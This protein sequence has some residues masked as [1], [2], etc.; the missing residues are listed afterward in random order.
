MRDEH[1]DAVVVGSGFG[2]SVMAYRLIEAGLRVCLLERGKAYPPGHFPRNPAAM[3]RNTWDPEAG[4]Q[5]LY[6]VWSFR[7][8]D[9]VVSSG[10]GG[11]SLIYSNVLLRK[12]EHWF[13]REQPTPGVYE[14]WPVTRADL[15]PHYDAVERMLPASPYPVQHAPYRHTPKTMAL[16]EAAP[17]SGGSW[18]L[19]PLGIS[20]ANRGEKPVPGVP[21][22]NAP[23]MFNA[24]RYTCRL[25]GE[26]NIGCNY[27]SKNSLD[28]HYLSAAERAGLEIRTR[29][30][31]RGLNPLGASSSGSSGYRITYVKHPAEFEGRP[32]RR[33]E[34]Q[35]HTVTASRVILAA[36]TF[37]STYLLL[38]MKRDVEAF[39]R[40]SPMLGQR[41]SGNGDMLSLVLRSRHRGD[42]RVPRIMDPTLGPVITG[43]IRMPDSVDALAQNDID[44]PGEAA[45]SN[46]GGRGFYIQDAG[47]PAFVAWMVE[48]APTLGTAGRMATFMRRYLAGHLGRTR[49]SNLSAEIAEFIGDA[50]LTDTSLPLLCMGRDTPSGTMRID[51]ADNLSVDWHMRESTEYVERVREVCRRI[52]EALG[53]TY[54]DNPLMRLRRLVTVHPL[55]GC[56]M[57]RDID[58]GLVDGDGQV[59]GYPGLYVADGSVM[60]GP[61]GPNPALTIAALSN[62]FADRVIDSMSQ[63]S[64][65]KMAVPHPGAP[66]LAQGA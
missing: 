65:L 9:S 56:P 55:G 31:V 14:H 11:G 53:G 1:F 47:F 60:P 61:V 43:A 66:N 12:D 64:G 36:G 33:A 49:D 27:G 35:T 52:A 63:Y 30:E 39:A 32:Y 17:A 15:E 6:D 19:P 5:G 42:R 38:R 59:F 46:R 24:P 13:V 25:C 44:L 7:G 57:G 22:E 62:R 37:G 18:L 2:G 4:K 26:C 34:L 10:L 21:L 41:F 3:S 23:N 54:A 20:F 50:S 16:R 8:V 48:S 29:C 40:L 58:E 28:L 51:D 45:N